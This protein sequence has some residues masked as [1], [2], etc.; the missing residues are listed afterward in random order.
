M[1]SC[2]DTG[3]SKNLKSNQFLCIL[4]CMVGLSCLVGKGGIMLLLMSSERSNHYKHFPYE[5]QISYTLPLPSFTHGILRQLLRPLFPP[6]IR[7]YSKLSTFFQSSCPPFN[8]SQE[9]TIL[10]LKKFIF[11]LNH[12]GGFHGFTLFLLVFR[13]LS[14]QKTCSHNLFGLAVF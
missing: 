8:Q 13:P 7:F 2:P 9:P 1:D 3:I 6:N 10:L 12:D 11:T 14:C 5:L 4:Q